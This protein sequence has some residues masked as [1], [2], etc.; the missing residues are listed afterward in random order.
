MTETTANTYD[1]QAA[2]TDWEIKAAERSRREA[3]LF[4]LNKTALFDALAA[5]DV[6]EVAV[7]F[8]GYG[9]E[10]QIESVEARICAVVVA[11]PE[12]AVAIIELTFDQTEPKHSSISI[13]EAI[14]RMAYDVLYRTCGGWQDGDGA[15]GDVVFDVEERIITLD[16]N[17]RY[18][19]SNNYTYTF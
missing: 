5:A 12:G 15:Y 9:D 4:D 19:A 3:E 6:T 11:M 7:N 17:E 13:A 10:G 18:T 2:P 1:Q 8:D 16:F 14:E